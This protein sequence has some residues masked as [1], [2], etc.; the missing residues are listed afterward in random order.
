LSTASKTA[1]PIV[2]KT[3]S[4]LENSFGASYTSLYTLIVFCNNALI[5]IVETAPSIVWALVIKRM[6]YRS[7][8]PKSF[9]VV[10][11]KAIKEIT[12]EALNV[13]YLSMLQ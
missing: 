4:H 9:L 11:S 5:K 3:L 10:S 6:I 12:P 2:V 7:F 1:N 8:N 13:R